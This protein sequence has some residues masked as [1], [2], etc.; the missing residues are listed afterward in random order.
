LPGF[1][2]LHAVQQEQF[3][4]A[5]QAVASAQQLDLMHATHAASPPAGAQNPPLELVLVLVL[6]L[7]PPLELEVVP[8][9]P[10][11]LELEE[12]DPA[13]VPLAPSAPLPPSPHA[14]PKA[15]AAIATAPTRNPR[16]SFAMPHRT[17]SAR[18]V[19][20]PHANAFRRPSTI[21]PH[22]PVDVT[23]DL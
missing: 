20:V 9:A 15:V 17:M 14:A 4:S 6:V 21:L 3:M 10:I 13:P 11:P 23:P 12:V 22:S 8:P 7:V 1:W 5:T 16:P 18:A 2:A 19:H